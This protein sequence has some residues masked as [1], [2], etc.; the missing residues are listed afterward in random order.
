MNLPQMVKDRPVASGVT[1]ASIIAGGLV[2]TQV[3]PSLELIVRIKNAPVVADAA[4]QKAAVAEE[5]ADASREWI[6][7]WIAE[8]KH[9]REMEQKVAEATVE[10]QRQMVE[11]QQQ[12]QQ[13]QQI[14]F[15]NPPAS[16]VEEWQDPDSG[17]WYCSEDG[18]YSWWVC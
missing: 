4:M 1:V 17:T 16:R 12:I 2:L 3:M 10:Y 11:L 8:Q 18:F 7:A 14:P 5:K 9:Q 6:E 15:P 13:Q